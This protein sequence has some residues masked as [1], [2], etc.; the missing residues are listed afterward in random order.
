MYGI[1]TY[2]YHK[3]QPHV[4][5]YTNP[6][7]PMERETTDSPS[8]ESSNDEI[9]LLGFKITRPE[10][11]TLPRINIIDHN[12]ISHPGKMNIIFN[13]CLGIGYFPWF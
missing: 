6:I 13:K 12:R 4:G 1:F 11:D 7:N 10:P 9:H 5:K 3:D 2:I 8:K